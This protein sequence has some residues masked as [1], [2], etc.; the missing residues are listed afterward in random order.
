MRY[1]GQSLVVALT[2]ACAVL[3]VRSDWSSSERD[4]VR[5]LAV[6]GVP[7]QAA[8]AVRMLQTRHPRSAELAYLLAVAYRRQGEVESAREE[9][10][11][12]EQ[13]GWPADELR[14][15]HAMI[16][17]GSQEMLGAEPRL[18][19]M[20]MSDTCPD[21]VAIQ[22]FECF[23][24]AYV[25]NGR[26]AEAACCLDFWFDWQPQGSLARRMETEMLEAIEE[27]P[28]RQEEYRAILAMDA[29][30]RNS[31][32]HALLLAHSDP[33]EAAERFE[34]HLQTWPDDRAARDGLARCL[35]VAQM[36]ATP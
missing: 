1:C 16:E 32:W 27:D 19:Q 24:R 4:R 12:A 8:S 29:T 28:A 2:V 20:I 18:V 5:G 21:D 14:W 3:F 22:V 36:S 31:L 11:R 35:K 33:R 9:L 23:V 26:Y 30:Q 34:R 13:L 10:R 15:Q 17:L 6:T 7:Q 25:A